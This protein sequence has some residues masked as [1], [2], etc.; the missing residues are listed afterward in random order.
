MVEKIDRPEPP[1]T[2]QVVATTAAK[3]QRGHAQPENQG[4]DEFSSPGAAAEWQRLRGV[5]QERKLLRIRREDIRR[6]IFRQAVLRSRAVSVDTNLELTNGQILQQ[7]QFFIPHLEEFWQ[8]KGYA[9]GQEIPLHL[10]LREPYVE[11]SV[12]QRGDIPSTAHWP[13]GVVPARQ[14][15][16]APQPWWALRDVRTGALRPPVVAAYLVAIVTGVTILWVIL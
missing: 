7:A 16:A 10:L 14:P 11:V 8:W 2:Y 12:P 5:A 9:P 15:T 13:P 4:E 3:D 6:A 1:P